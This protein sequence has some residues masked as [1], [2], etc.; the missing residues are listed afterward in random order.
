MKGIIP[1]TLR[2]KTSSLY[3]SSAW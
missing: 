3:T 1:P 2:Y